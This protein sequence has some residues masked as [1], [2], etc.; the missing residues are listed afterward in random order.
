MKYCVI[1]GVGEEG[2]WRAEGGVR[3]QEEGEGGGEEGWRDTSGSRWAAFTSYFN[4]N[5]MFK[6]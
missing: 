2:C 3:L 4:M 6:D 5:F 1:K